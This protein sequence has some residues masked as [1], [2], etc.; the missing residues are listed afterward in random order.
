[1]IHGGRHVI[2]SA[3]RLEKTLVGTIDYKFGPHVSALTLIPTRLARSARGVVEALR[4]GRTRVLYAVPGGTLTG[5]AYRAGR[6]GVAE[7]VAGLRTLLET[8]RSRRAVWFGW[9]A[10]ILLIW[11]L[12]TRER[13][14]SEQ[15]TKRR[16]LGTRG[17]RILFILCAIGE[18]ATPVGLSWQVREMVGPV[19]VPLLL[20]AAALL[21]VPLLAAVQVLERSSGRET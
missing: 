14:R 18:I 16:R 1:V 13:E 5:E 21:A 15:T 20:A 7:T 6:P 8:P 12:S 3:R 19:P 9:L 10:A 11:R 2:E 17:A 4:S